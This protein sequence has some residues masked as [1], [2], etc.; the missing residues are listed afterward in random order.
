MRENLSRNY[1]SEGQYG[2]LKEI[3]KKEWRR[4][5]YEQALES[6]QQIL[7]NQEPLLKINTST[8]VVYLCVLT[9]EL[10]RG[11]LLPTLWLYIESMGGTKSYQ[12]FAIG[13][14]SLGRIV[15]APLFGYLSELYGH[16]LP[17]ILCNV[18][19]MIGSTLYLFSPTVMWIIF[20]QT[21]IGFGAG[22]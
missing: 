16:Q 22:K 19:I 9:S 6:D 8:L 21:L 1:I 7:S 2:S 17:L 3:N 20:S 10:A 13:A 4:D 11:I 15:G 14:F 5:D 12:G 18:I